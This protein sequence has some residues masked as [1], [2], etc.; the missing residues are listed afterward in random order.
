MR[1]CHKEGD[2]YA[3]A[4]V[5]ILSLK[6]RTGEWAREC[7][8]RELQRA[9]E[10]AIKPYERHD[11]IGELDII[12]AS[13]VATKATRWLWRASLLL[14]R[15]GLRLQVREQL[16]GQVGRQLATVARQMAGILCR[17]RIDVDLRG[18]EFAGRNAFSY[19]RFSRCCP[20]SA[21]ETHIPGGAPTLVTLERGLRLPLPS[22]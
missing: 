13:D 8:E 15:Q 18:R 3:R 14:R 21:D 16:G 5:K 20:A 22:L 2:T 7:G 10:Q 19:R 9:W 17:M 11:E 6:N 12:R 1:Q 4:R